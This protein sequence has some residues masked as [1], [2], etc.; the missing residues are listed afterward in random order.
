MSQ[1]TESSRIGSGGLLLGLAKLVF[2]VA[3]YATSIAL[4]HLISPTTFGRYYVV[5]RLIAVPNMV[6]IQTLLFAVSRPMAAERAAGFPSYGALRRRGIRL[7]LGLGGVTA[8]A[9]FVAAPLLGEVLTDSLLVPAIRVVAPISLLYALYAVNIGTLN[10][11]RRFSLQASL[12][13][14]MAVAKASLIVGAAVAGMGL[15]ATLG[16]FTVA[17][18][19]AL[20]LSIVLVMRARPAGAGMSGGGAP[21]MATFAGILIVFT[22]A[23]NFLQSADVLI[24]KH[25]A[26]T[27]A[28]LDAV[29][30][31]STAQQVALVPYSLMNAV[32]LLM[33]PLIAS[34]HAASDEGRVRVYV[35]ETAKLCLLLLTFMSVV[36]SACADEIQALLFPSAYGAAASNLRYLVWGFSG[37]SFAVTTAWIFNSSERSRVAVSLVLLPLLLVFVGAAAL[38]PS[39]FTAGAA[40]SV[41]VA[42]GVA[43]V[44]ALAALWWKFRAAIPVAYALKIAL[45]VA[46]VVGA[47]QLWPAVDGVG[48]VGKVLV[49]VKLAVL[50]GLFV[51]LVVATRAVTLRD[52][53]ELRRAG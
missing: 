50:S 4:T 11:T 48:L 2:L 34:L 22:L 8:A 3:A 15:A 45:A 20:L 12:D 27:R 13:I 5:A 32:S 16:G 28:E 44:V 23:V 42:G 9:F 26:S 53:R 43:T 52:I 25:F 1:T 19:L 38:I 37:Y 10:A 24:L 31:Y 17:S 18:G 35:R 39:S 51:A 33:F 47:A 46:A 21:P 7:A 14:F 29:G 30:Y 40:V 36:G 41:A 49:L 6:I